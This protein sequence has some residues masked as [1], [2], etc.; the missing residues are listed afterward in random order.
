M[1][2]VIK[3]VISTFMDDDSDVWPDPDVDRLIKQ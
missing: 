1:V 3:N 2:K